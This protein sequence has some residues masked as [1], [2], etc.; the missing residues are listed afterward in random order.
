MASEHPFRDT[1][2]YAQQYGEIGRPGNGLGDISPAVE[3][4]DPLW[5]EDTDD[6]LP[7]G[8]SVWGGALLS[9]Y[10]ETDS[11]RLPNQVENE[12]EIH[13]LFDDQ[14]RPMV[15]CAYCHDSQQIRSRT[16]AIAWFHDHACGT[17]EQLAA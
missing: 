17:A 7:Y 15:V 6:G 12:A 9:G 10:P 11:Y 14:S 8:W 1:P 16:N 5:D 3:E 13:A 4:D 2:Q